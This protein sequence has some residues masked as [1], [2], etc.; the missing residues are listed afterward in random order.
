MCVLVLSLQ[1][2]LEGKDL[3]LKLADGTSLLEAETLGGLLQTTNHRRRTA[4]ENLDIFG[5]LRE[6]FL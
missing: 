6:P 2:N 1:V 4:E 5:G 3:I